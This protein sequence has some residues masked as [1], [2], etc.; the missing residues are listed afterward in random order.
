MPSPRI[1]RA[2]TQGL[3]RLFWWLAVGAGALAA[4]TP[5]YRLEV[6][7]IYPHDKTAFTQGLEYHDG[8]LYEG[9]GLE[10]RSRLRVERLA[11]GKV[12]REVPIDPTLFGEGISVL[13]GRVYQL[14]WLGGKGFVYDA[15]TF[16][17]LHEFNYPGQGWGLTN[18]GKQLY[19]SD[20]TAQIRVWDA[21]SLKELRRITVHDGDQQI[22]QLNELEWVH[23]EIW[24]NIW[25]TA[26]IARISPVDGQVTGWIDAKGLLK[27]G[28]ATNPDAVLNGIAYD[29]HTNRIFVT[30]KL[31]PKIFEVRV[32]PK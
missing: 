28:E 8:V 29:S 16:R 14:T 20:G 21:S 18:D 26:S 17:R 32:R 22:N 3:V 9:T 23:G 1:A 31:W 13:G 6:V 4:A 12:I 19:M 27:A 7:H 5:E 25:T 11:T 2:E 15:K 10:G 24:A 30:G